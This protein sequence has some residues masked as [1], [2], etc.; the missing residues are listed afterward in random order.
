MVFG[1][2]GLS[3]ALLLP[4]LGQR[5]F[6]DDEAN[7]AI[8]ARNLLR[9]GRIT[10]WD[11]TNLSGYGLGGALGED[12]G[13]EL[14]VPTLP[15]Y[16]AAASM[17]LLGPTTFAGRLPFALAGVVS[18]GLLAVWMRRHF[19]RRFPWYVPSLLMAV[20]PAFLLYARNCRYYSLGLMFSLAV[21]AFWAPGARRPD[22]QADRWL[23]RGDLWRSI[24]AAV[25]YSLL[26]WTPLSQRGGVA[27]GVA[28]DVPRSPLPAAAAGYALRSARGDGGRRWPVGIGNRQSTCNPLRNRPGVELWPRRRLRIGGRG[29]A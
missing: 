22:R 13:Q 15:A 12:L 5:L 17:G 7:T 20:S 1:A 18:V 27:G 10:A 19:G 24:G 16:I 21:L 2:M 29:S 23:S 6:W 4:R 14:R 28:A 25:A 26:V 9:F 11:G 3:A 8:Y